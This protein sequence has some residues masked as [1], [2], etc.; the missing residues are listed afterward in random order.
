MGE[1]SIELNELN[2]ASAAA[3]Q[4]HFFVR[5]SESESEQQRWKRHRMGQDWEWWETQK[6]DQTC[7][8]TAIQAQSM[9][10][11]RWCP[12]PKL[13]QGWGRQTQ[14]DAVTSTATMQVAADC[15]YLPPTS[16]NWMHRGQAGQY[17]LQTRQPQWTKSDLVPLPTATPHQF[18]QTAQPPSHQSERVW[19]QK[20][21]L[22]SL[23][24]TSK[25]RD[26]CCT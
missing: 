22:W 6:P 18:A 20:S 24:T 25:S 1:S 19:V 9:W 4:Q 21:D 8:C 12:I 10:D 16:I 15:P 3:Q 11:R 2:I 26:C 13:L 5:K 23:N 17:S 14:L 7:T